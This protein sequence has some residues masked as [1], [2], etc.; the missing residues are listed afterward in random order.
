MGPGLVS[1]EKLALGKLPTDVWWHTIVSPTGREKT[2]GP[3]QKPTGV[4]RRIIRA[5][6]LPGDLVLDFF[7]GSGTTG[8]AA[9]E[10]GRRFT[11]IDSADGAIATMRRRLAGVPDVSWE[12]PDLSTN[13][14]VD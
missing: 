10:L 13:R 4:L 5:F 11:L 12:Q 7:A 9:A 3:I 8:V 2:G 1:L 14:H 6:S